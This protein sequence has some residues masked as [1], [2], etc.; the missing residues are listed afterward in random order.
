MIPFP[1]TSLQTVAEVF[2]P[3]VHENPDTTPLHP[4]LH[5]TPSL[6]PSSHVS[7]LMT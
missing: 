5:P 3:P 2:V 4:V 1:H 6:D 7:G